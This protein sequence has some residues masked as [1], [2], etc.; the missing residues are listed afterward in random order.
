M[1]YVFANNKAQWQQLP[2]KG[3]TI[4]VLFFLISRV[5]RVLG[6]FTLD[7]W[8]ANTATNHGIP[9]WCL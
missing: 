6:S 2:D 5:V 3:R 8:K 7:L 4:K 1:K 9:E